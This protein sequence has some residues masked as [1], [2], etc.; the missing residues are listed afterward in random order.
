MQS[1][2]HLGF[3]HQ[4]N[5]NISKQNSIYTSHLIYICISSSDSFFV[6]CDKNEKNLTNDKSKVT[7]KNEKEIQ[8]FTPHLYFLFIIT[9]FLS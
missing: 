4:I 2:N 3:G 5:M 8:L 9:H 1:C 7:E 6:E